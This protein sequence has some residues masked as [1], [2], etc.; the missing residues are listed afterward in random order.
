MGRLHGTAETAID[1]KDY[2]CGGTLLLIRGRIHRDETHLVGV[3]DRLGPVGD[4]ELGED[5]PEVGF[6]RRLADPENGGEFLVRQAS[7]KVA[8]RS[9]SAAV[10]DA[11]PDAKQVPPFMIF[12][13]ACTTSDPS[14]DFD[15]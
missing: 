8:L 4:V 6:D 15:K 1:R 12:L 7:A 3:G 10:S 14:A 13:I 2:F 9:H 11:S 5:R